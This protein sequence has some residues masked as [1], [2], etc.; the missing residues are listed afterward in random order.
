M[1]IEATLELPYTTEERGWS[2]TTAGVGPQS[3]HWPFA[4]AGVASTM[5]FPGSTLEG[6][7]EEEAS[8]LTERWLHPHTPDD[9]WSPDFPFS[10]L[11]R[12]AE[13]ALEIG[14]ALAEA[15]PEAAS[16]GTSSR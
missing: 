14:R 7:S 5:L 3:D 12:Y 9:E 10:G 1:G 8:A 13:L 16:D 6:L 15:S 4:Q 11:E 2:V